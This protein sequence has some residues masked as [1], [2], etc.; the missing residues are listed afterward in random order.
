MAWAGLWTSGYS[1][2]KQETGYLD[3]TCVSFLI[4]L[5]V[6]DLFSLSLLAPPNGLLCLFSHGAGRGRR[7]ESTGPDD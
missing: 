5:W 7:V 1:H 3:R 6:V 2:T 4:M